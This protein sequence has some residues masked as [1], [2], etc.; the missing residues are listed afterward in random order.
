M[1]L[2]LCCFGVGLVSQPEFILNGVR[3][4]G[5]QDV[6]KRQVNGG[7]LA[8]V[9]ALPYVKRYPCIVL[10]AGAVTALPDAAEGVP[11]SL[12]HI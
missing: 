6:Y 1:V 9:K 11:L 2:L 8:L 12:I 10:A 7:A 4:A 3:G 5:F